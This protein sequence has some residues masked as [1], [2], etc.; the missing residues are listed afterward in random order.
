[1]TS[2]R[3]RKRR[4]RWLLWR[5]RLG[6]KII[7]RLSFADV[8]RSGGL[9]TERAGHTRAKVLPTM[10][11]RAREFGDRGVAALTPLLLD[12]PQRTVYRRATRSDAGGPMQGK[13]GG[14]NRLRETP[15][16]ASSPETPRNWYTPPVVPEL[17][18]Q[19][20]RDTC[21]LS[22]LYPRDDPR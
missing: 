12:K 8:P 20:G 2:Y 4:K 21:R 6:V 7:G 16:S 14:S 17:N 9:G 19:S 11:C 22:V 13:S 5:K 10:T 15:E 1:M 3:E 18:R